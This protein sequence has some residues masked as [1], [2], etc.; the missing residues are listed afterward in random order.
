MKNRNKA[1]F[2]ESLTISLIM[3]I[4]NI[5]RANNIIIKINESNNV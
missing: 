2:L 3:K 1:H 5:D 4:F